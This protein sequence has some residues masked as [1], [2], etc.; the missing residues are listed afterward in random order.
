ME[1][2]KPKVKYSTLIQD[3]LLGGI[4]LPDLEARLKTQR[5]V[6][7][8]RLL[9]GDFKP[10][11]QIAYFHLKSI[12]GFRHIRSNFNYQAIPKTL[13]QFYK[14]CL[15]DWA[16]FSACDPQTACQVLCQP[17][18]SNACISSKLDK[19]VNPCLSS[20][21]IHNV[22]D[23]F[24]DKAQLKQLNNF[25]PI[26]SQV[27][28]QQFMAWL[29]L[30]KS[31]PRSWIDKVL[32]KN[33]TD[34]SINE[35]DFIALDSFIIDIKGLTAQFF[36]KRCLS[37]KVKDPTGKLKLEEKSQGTITW[38]DACNILYTTTID[39]Y[40]R[41]FQYRILNNYL[42]VNSVLF[43]WKVVD[44]MRCSYCFINNESLEHL[45]CECHVAVT[46]YMQVKN[47]CHSMDLK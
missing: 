44:S 12:G 10:W 14:S 5:L 24:S 13:P 26:N 15:N 7:V 20:Y 18:W 40:S 27:Y 21:G 6:W 29:T 11:K 28:K 8:K 17:L 33:E 32:A 46:L 3:K 41:Q 38:Q 4:S 37:S 9:C 1:R 30:I 45:F 2:K 47:W 43:K 16:K 36:Y 22:G 31:I 25:I 39:T 35:N 19:T 42:H 23:L 34:K